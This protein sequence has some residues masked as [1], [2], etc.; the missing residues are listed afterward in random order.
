MERISKI[1]EVYQNALEIY[2]SGLTWEVK[3]DLIFSSEVSQH[4][5]EFLDYY[6]PDSGYDDDV[7]AF[8]DAFTQFM[9]CNNL[10]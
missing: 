3:Y 4:V 9:K 8:M 5:N 6:D 2:T 10:I 1:K 7:R